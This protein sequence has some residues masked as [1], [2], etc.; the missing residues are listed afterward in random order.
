MMENSAD[1][2]RHWN[3]ICLGIST[4]ATAVIGAAFFA[5]NITADVTSG[6]NLILASIA[7]VSYLRLVVLSGRTIFTASNDLVR[8]GTSKRQQAHLVFAWFSVEI[9]T[10]IGILINELFSTFLKSIISPT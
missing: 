9:V 4:I 2:E 3:T 6:M 1:W 5:A 10:L 8:R 7:I